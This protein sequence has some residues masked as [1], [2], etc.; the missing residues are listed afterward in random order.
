[1]FSSLSKK[2][3][4]QALL[5]KNIPIYVQFYITARCNIT[6]Q[7]CN[8]IYSNSDL[9]ECTI[10]EI[11]KI[12]ENLASIGVAIVLLTGGEPFVRKDLPDIV[13]AF[14]SRGIHVRMQTNGLATEK[15]IDSVIEAGGKDISISLDTL[16]PVLQNNINGNFNNTWEKAIMAMGMFM[17][18]LPIDDSFASIGC[19]LQKDNIVDVES[20]IEFGTAIGWYTSLVPIHVTSYSN[21]RGFQ[22][23]DN[24]L[25]FGL[26]YFDQIKA[27]IKKIRTMRHKG[28]LLYDSDQY[29]DDIL[30]F[31][32][33]EPVEWRSHNHN[34]CD[35]PNLYF[36]I[37]PNGEFAPC[38]DHRTATS[39][40]TYSPDFPKLYHDQILRDETKLVTESCDGC[41]YGSY[42]EMTIAMRFLRATLQ[43]T[44]NFLTAPPKKPWPITGKQAL[45]VIEDIRIQTELRKQ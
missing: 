8:I 24:N 44:K 16:N 38:C 15:Q 40:Y 13:N 32:C 11:E 20:V 19:V 18:K 17:E 22:T 34:V 14:E 26:E 23:F 33:N 28:Y 29:L 27:L 36:A 6:C 5:F 42:P 37:L 9:P 4:A 3:L 12:A 39:F 45:E 31:I 21:P 41:M 35:T 2:S 25:R 10:Y 30:R 43:R 7:Q 1:M